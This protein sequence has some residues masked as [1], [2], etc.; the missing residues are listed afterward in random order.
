MIRI[1]VGGGLP[2][3]LMISSI[4]GVIAARIGLLRAENLVLERT[5]HIS[6]PTMS[7]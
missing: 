6:S 5:K 2:V 3:L 1:A 4:F 7:R